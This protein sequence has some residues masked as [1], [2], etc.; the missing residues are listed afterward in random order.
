MTTT[1]SQ[2]GRVR[3]NLADQIDRLDGILDGLSEALQSVVTQAVQE[4]V[5]VAVREAVQTALTEIFTNPALLSLL[6]GALAPETPA[7]AVPASAPTS[8]TDSQ[9]KAAG[10]R[11]R[12]IRGW[13]AR[14]WH[15]ARALCAGVKN[16]L[17]RRCEV[18]RQFWRPLLLACFVGLVAGVLGYVA[19]PW[20]T[21]GLGCIGGFAMTLLIQI[22][23]A[24]RRAFAMPGLAMSMAVASTG[25]ATPRANGT[26]RI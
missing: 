3:K 4:A 22:M 24:L 26:D 25:T 12:P 17:G 6:R 7:E 20:V 1:T 10:P 15:G 19:A 14:R 2:N 5:G 23:V 11:R 8:T 9:P 16:W 13:M 21:A 18:V